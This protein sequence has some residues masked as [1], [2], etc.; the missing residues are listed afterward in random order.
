V[1]SVDGARI[2][3]A[4]GLGAED[5]AALTDD[6]TGPRT[7]LSDAVYA[8]VSATEIREAARQG[9]GERLRQLVPSSVAFYIDKYGL[10]RK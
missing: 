1:N 7:F 5:I 6:S 10:Y 3:D 9:N 8:D 2:S 4:R